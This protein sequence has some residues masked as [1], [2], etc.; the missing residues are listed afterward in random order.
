[1]T[2]INAKSTKDAII[3][4]AEEII[5]DRE[6]KLHTQQVLSKNLLEERNTVL[7][8]LA[9]LSAFTILF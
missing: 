3:T 2:C 4:A 5:E 7:V 8:L 6:T 9:A 1:M